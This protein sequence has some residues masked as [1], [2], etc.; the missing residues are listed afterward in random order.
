MPKPTSFTVSVPFNLTVDVEVGDIVTLYFDGSPNGPIN[1]SN[2]PADNDGDV[3]CHITAET[4]SGAP[5][6]QA[7][8]FSGP[9]ASKFRLTNGGVP[10]CELVVGTADLEPGTHS[11]TWT[12]S[13]PAP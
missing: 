13:A 12:F 2:I 1:L 9:E 4:V 6:E 5:Y 10:P 7:I 8:S 3:V 11:G